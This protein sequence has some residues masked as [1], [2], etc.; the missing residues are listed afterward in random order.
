MVVKFLLPDEYSEQFASLWTR[1]KEDDITVIGPPLL[2]AEVP[3]VIREAVFFH[4]IT[5][6][7]GEQAFAVFLDMGI[8]IS[9]RRDLHLLAW[10]LA[11]RHNRPRTYDSFYLAAAQ[12]EGCELW[13]GDRRLFNA[14]RL[15]WVRWIGG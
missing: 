8:V 15:P 11:K 12:A 9:S 5:P 1:W 10:E 3:S 2:Y 14:V 4:R 6:E 7:E 13:T